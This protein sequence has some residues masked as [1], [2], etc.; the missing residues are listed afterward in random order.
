M[1]YLKVAMRVNPKSAHHKKKKF[2]LVSR[3][4]DGH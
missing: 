3:W 1:L 2:F 4:G